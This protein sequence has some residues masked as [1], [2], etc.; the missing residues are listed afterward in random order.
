MFL[1]IDQFGEKY[2]LKTKYPRKELEK[3]FCTK[4]IKKI[5]IDDK[6]GN[7]FHTGYFLKGLWLNLYKLQ[8][9]KNKNH[10]LTGFF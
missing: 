5:Y 6:K 7:S 4:N 8:S 1:A 2:L 3:I 9:L 10:V